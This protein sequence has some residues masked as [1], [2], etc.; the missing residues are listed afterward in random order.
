[1]L[2]DNTFQFKDSRS[3]IE[4]VIKD[5]PEIAPHGATSVN[6]EDL[7]RFVSDSSITDLK[8]KTATKIVRDHIDDFASLDEVGRNGVVTVAELKLAD[9]ILDPKLPP[10]LEN[11]IKNERAGWELA[12]CG[13]GDVGIAAGLALVPEPTMLTKV[14]AATLAPAGLLAAAAGVK[15]IK[16]ATDAHHLKFLVEHTAPQ[17]RDWTLPK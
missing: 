16:D 11:D 1:M 14:I 3:A 15:T 12:V 7:S 6:A 4:E 13:V 17:L 5:L 2:S 10:K 9:R 8:A